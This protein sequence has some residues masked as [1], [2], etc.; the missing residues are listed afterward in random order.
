MAETGRLF[1]ESWYRI[2]NQRICLRPSVRVQRQ[3]F[4]GARWYILRDPFSNQFYRLPP[5][6]YAFVSRLNSERTVEEV[7]KEVVNNEPTEAPGQSD[8]IELL[9]QLYHANLLHYALPPDSEK[10]FDRYK[11]KKQRILK[12]NLKSIMFFRIPLFDPNEILQRL[13]SF[14]RVLLSPLG[15]IIW[16]LTVIGAIKVALDHAGE[17]WVQSQSILAPSNLFLLYIGII[18]IK[19]LHEFGHAFAVRRYG[20]EVHTMG[21]MFLIFSPLPYMDATAAWFFRNKW[22]RILVGAAGMIVE[23]FVAA[24]ALFIWANTGPGVIHTLSYNMVFVASVSTVVFNINPLLRFDGYYILSDFLDMPN[25]HQHSGQHLKYLVEHHA[26]GCKNAE[27]PATSKRDEIWFTTFGILSGVY[28]IVVFAM[29]FLFVADQFLLAGLIMAAICLVTWG[30]VPVVG[31]V[32]YL[33][34]SPKLARVRTRAVFVSIATFTVVVSILFIFPFPFS[35]QAPG[36]LK[37]SDYVVVTNKVS[38]RMEEILVPSGTK[39]ARN[40]PL[41][42]LVNPELAFE[43]Q[44]SQSELIEA[45]AAYRKAMQNQQSDLGPIASRIDYYQKRIDRITREQKNQVVTAEISG[46]WVARDLKDRLGMWQTRGAP[47]GELINEDSFQFV[48]VVAQSDVS[49]LF[50]EGIRKTETKLIGQAGIRIQVADFAVIPMEQTRLPSMALGWSGGG[51]I[52]V[53]LQ[54]RQGIQTSEPYYQVRANLLP[55]PEVATLHGRSGRIQFFLPPKSLAEQGWRK[56][57]QMIQDRYQ[58]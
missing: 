13:S 42:R 57:L 23:I 38:G 45:E 7:W 21:V 26:F 24:C 19:A 5:G 41:L 46:T 1:H 4:R 15:A 18:I 47:F 25:L 40:T 33:A 56:L 9:A 44:E 53:N 54:D 11:K 36:V 52:A 37:S 3:M 34:T 48:S 10:L 22:H 28:R 20:G 43:L 8:I 35:V 27:T 58:L 49:E 55:N 16:V 32:R 17:L 31:I 6:A 14:I 30:I 39:V 50:A 2:A 29:I 12:A 51:D